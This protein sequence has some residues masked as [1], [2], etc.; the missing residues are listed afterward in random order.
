MQES[1]ASCPAVQGGYMTEKKLIWTT[2]AVSA[3]ALTGLFF[4]LRA[5][6]L[7]E[8]SDRLSIL[9]EGAVIQHDADP[10]RQLPIS[11]V[12]VTASDGTR[13]ATGQ[14]DASGYYKLVLTKRVLSE[15]PITVTFQHA[16]YEPGEITIPT[17]RFQT[18]NELHVV[19]LE[20]IGPPR[21]QKASTSV[22]ATKP[23]MVVSDIRVRYTV[24]NRS[25]NNVGS[26]TR[27][28]EVVNKGDIPCEQKSLCSPD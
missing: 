13:T 10:N 11:D 28:F 17:A 15:L 2:I 24:N 7:R 25:E 27:T 14:T 22:P 12:L 4:F 26:A 5:H 21:V 1:F 19:A 23:P 6:H 9:I 18:A 8:I 16:G 20:P 3:A